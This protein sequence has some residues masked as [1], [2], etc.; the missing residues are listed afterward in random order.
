MAFG[1][2]VMTGLPAGPAESQAP[3][4][5]PADSA[6]VW[7]FP[8][9]HWAHAGYQTEWWYLTG[10]LTPAGD[11][12]PRFGYQFTFFRVGLLPNGTELQSTWAATDLIMG[13][14]ALTDRRTGHH[15]FSEIVYRA[16][17]LLGTFQPFPDTLLAWSRGPPGTAE[18]WTLAWN[19]AAFNVAMQ[20][21]RARTGFA[22]TTRPAKPL[23]FQG[24]NGFSRKGQGP[25]AASQYYS[26]TRLVTSGTVVMDG[27]TLAV[28]GTS[29]MDKEFGSNQLAPGQVGWDWFSLH[30]DDGRELMLYVLRDSTGG[31]DYGRGTLVAAEGAVRFLTP[32]DWTIDVRARWRS[33]ATGAVYPARW[34]VRVPSAGL[35]LDLE[36]VVANQENVSRLIADLAYWEGAV[37]VRD[38]RG[39]V[40]G[41]GYVELTGYAVLGRLPL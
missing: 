26:F 24:P 36:P 35:E 39:A 13:H 11:T 6:Y 9:D 16:T 4:W 28:R 1:V 10:H 29:W 27:D 22:L 32:A 12:A 20:D 21:T 15:R 31:V 18:R 5:Q 2:L 8:R 41:R 19:G 23:V 3:A 34:R 17:P 7:A 25:T 30:L 38:G 33:D 40:I 37:V 14:A